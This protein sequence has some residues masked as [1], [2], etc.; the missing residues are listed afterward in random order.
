[1]RSGA[2]GECRQIFE[3]RWSILHSGILEIVYYKKWIQ[4]C[5]ARRSFS[6]VRLLQK[7]IVCFALLESW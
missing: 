1:M 5:M 3:L 6:S 4:K 7:L 2:V